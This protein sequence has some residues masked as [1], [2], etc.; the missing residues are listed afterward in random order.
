MLDHIKFA[1]G[2]KVLDISCGTGNVTSLLAEKV[3]SQSQIIGVDPDKDRIVIAKRNNKFPNVFY[4]EGYGEKFPEDQYDF[5]FCNYVMP[6]IEDKEAVFNQVIQN[7]K[8][9]GNFLLIT[10]VD[11]APIVHEMTK[12]MHPEIVD[13]MQQFF[14][15]YKCP[16]SVY[17]NYARVSGF[18]IDLKEE[19][20]D[21]LVCPTPEA[22]LNNLMGIT[23][24]IFDPAKADPGDVAK[25]KEKY[26]EKE[27]EWPVPV[28]RYILAK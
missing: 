1:P 10:P 17:D 16:S 7:L 20:T 24:G 18:K 21:S 11:L 19:D 9:K 4:I 3:G 22:A 5:V 27:I 26:R 28:V 2:H 13:T 14:R 15:R 6:L 23:H 25:F 12:L 8:V